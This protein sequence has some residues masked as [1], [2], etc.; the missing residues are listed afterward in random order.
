MRLTLETN[1][2]QAVLA[3]VQL[4]F[5]PLYVSRLISAQVC[6]VSSSSTALVEELVL[7]LLLC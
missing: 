1:Y 5:P 6:R 2:V 3:A 7:A 4:G